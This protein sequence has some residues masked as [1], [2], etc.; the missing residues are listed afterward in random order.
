MGARLTWR[1]TEALKW[2]VQ[3]LSIK[4]VGRKMGVST[5]TADVH[6]VAVR[7]KLGVHKR[8]EAI[9]VTLEQLKGCEQ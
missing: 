9:A 6:L 5:K 7:S 1:Q 3:G 4:E 2:Y 8:S